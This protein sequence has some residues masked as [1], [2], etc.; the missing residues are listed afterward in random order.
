VSDWLS[1]ISLVWGK[2]I[3]VIAFVGV[4]VWAW[5]R[6]RNFIF[7]GSPDSSRWR[8]LRLWASILIAIQIVIY[9]T[10]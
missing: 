1:N 7:Q 9:L 8:D 2:I 3:A 5:R 10:F 4:A 6:P